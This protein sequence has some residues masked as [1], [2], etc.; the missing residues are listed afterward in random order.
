M[1]LVTYFFQLGPTSESFHHPPIIPANYEF[2]HG[3]NPSLSNPLLNGLAH[4]IETKPLTHELFWRYT[5]Y[6][7]YNITHDELTYELKTMKI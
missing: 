2:V 3:F 5:S 1:L 6:P 7:N 4:P